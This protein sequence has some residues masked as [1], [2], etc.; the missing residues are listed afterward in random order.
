MCVL[1]SLSIDPLYLSLHFIWSACVAVNRKETFPAA[2]IS[3]VKKDTEERCGK[4]K[5]RKYEEHSAECEQGKSSFCMGLS[6]LN[7]LV[8]GGWIVV[9]A[10]VFLFT[11]FWYLLVFNVLFAFPWRLMMNSG[12]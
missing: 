11:L 1:R 9:S 2:L 3:R 4:K 6:E 12:K 5:R 8:S 10:V 7:D